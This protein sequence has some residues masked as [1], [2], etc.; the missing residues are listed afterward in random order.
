VGEWL[1]HVGEW[2]GR[3]RNFPLTNAHP[4]AAHAAEAAEAAA[5][6]G[7]FWEMHDYLY[8]HQQALD[9]PHLL[10]AAEHLGLD[11]ARFRQEMEAQTYAARLREDFMGGVRSDVNGTPSFF[12]N[13]VRH[14]ASY[15]LETL[16]AAL[17][18]AGA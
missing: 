13:G 10:Q 16:Q 8:E 4:H 7:M 9:D 17:D 11:L 5:A 14:D 15:D 3:I 12:V 2:R 18:R 6:Q 1:G